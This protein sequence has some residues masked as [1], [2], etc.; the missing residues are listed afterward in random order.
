MISS[1]AERSDHL[2]P[3]FSASAPRAL[4]EDGP[5]SRGLF[6]APDDAQMLSHPFS[7]C[8]PDAMA[9]SPWLGKKKQKF[10]QKFPNIPLVRNGRVARGC[11]VQ[12]SHRAFLETQALRREEETSGL[13][14]GKPQRAQ[15]AVVHPP[16]G[17]DFR[18]QFWELNVK[19]CPTL[20]DPMDCSLPG[21]SVHAIFQAIVLEWIAISFSKGSSQPRGRI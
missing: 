6:P 20:Y 1:G 18:S 7:L 15:N 8:V 9:T 2:S 5:W 19:S 21:S 13:P 4:W 10:P 16:Q 11:Q 14:G 17:R 12:P 3:R